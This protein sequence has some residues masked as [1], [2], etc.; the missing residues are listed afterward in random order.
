MTALNGTGTAAPSAFG[1]IFDSPRSPTRPESDSLTPVGNAAAN[2]AP[3]DIADDTL[4]VIGSPD[5]HVT[6]AE[7]RRDPRLIVDQDGNIWLRS[8][9]DIVYDAAA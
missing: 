2:S 1:V 7:A 6:L 3:P 5:E 8:H 4:I 9:Y